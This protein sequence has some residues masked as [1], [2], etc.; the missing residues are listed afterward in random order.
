VDPMPAGARVLRMILTAADAA[1]QQERSN[2]IACSR[3]ET[4]LACLV[5][6]RQ[7]LGQCSQP[8]KLQNN[9]RIVSSRK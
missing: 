1:L 2:L 5:T 3:Y 7:L 6:S 4:P 8:V 9:A